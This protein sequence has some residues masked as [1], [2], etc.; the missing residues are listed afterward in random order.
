[1]SRGWWRKWS[2]HVLNATLS[3]LPLWQMI[4]QDTHPSLLI[5]VPFLSHPRWQLDLT[6][7]TIVG[8]IR[9]LHISSNTPCLSLKHFVYTL[10]SISLRVTII[11]RRYWKTN[12]MQNFGGANKVYYG[13]CPNDECYFRKAE[14]SFT[15]ISKQSVNLR[16]RTWVTKISPKLKKFSAKLYIPLYCNVL[17]FC[18]IL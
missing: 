4:N 16:N 15:H 13:G 6:N 8:S 10:S 2:C 7:G 9:H 12:V 11:P 1:M 14:A 5:S 17:Y 18:S 3:F